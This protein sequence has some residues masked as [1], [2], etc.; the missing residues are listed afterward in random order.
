MG[1][2]PKHHTFWWKASLVPS[3]STG[4]DSNLPTPYLLLTDLLRMFRIK[5]RLLRFFGIQDCSVKNTYLGFNICTGAC[6]HKP[7]GLISRSERLTVVTSHITYKRLKF[8][9]STFV[10]CSLRRW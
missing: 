9:A 2:K 4:E 6:V 5:T 1:I 3:W 8:T 7:G 10:A